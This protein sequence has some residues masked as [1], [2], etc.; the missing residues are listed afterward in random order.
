MKLFIDFA[1][2]VAPTSV[3]APP[4][5]FGSFRNNLTSFI[6]CIPYINVHECLFVWAEMSN[7][8]NLEYVLWYAISDLDAY[9]NKVENSISDLI[10][11]ELLLFASFFEVFREASND[12]TNAVAALTIDFSLSEI[13]LMGLF[14]NRAS[15]LRPSNSISVP[16][17][18]SPLVST[19]IDTL[20]W[21]T[22]SSKLCGRMRGKG[23]RLPL[24]HSNDFT[25]VNN[26]CKKLNKCI[27]RPE[28]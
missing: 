20:D 25:N 15:Y 23:F 26:R 22:N 5:T 28:P 1:Q 19:W 12:L 18:S 16:S 17:S 9:C 10:I 11:F 7:N 3:V 24:N 13:L 8:S 27:T 6:H 2:I 14:W 4:W 21:S